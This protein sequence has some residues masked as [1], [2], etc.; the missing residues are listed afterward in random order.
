[1]IRAVLF[2]LDET[3]V[4]FR[5][6]HKTELLRLG[7]ERSYAYLSAHELSMPNF[8]QFRRKQ[9][10]IHR[11]IAWK[12][13]LTGAETDGRQ[14]LRRMCRDYGLQR[15]EPS[16]IKLGWLWFEP[17]A[18]RARVAADV[19]PTLEQLRDAGLHLGLVVNTNHLG[20]VNDMMLEN[21]GLLKFFTVRAYSTEVG[22]R[23]PAPHLFEY[24]L[25]QM[26]VSPTQALFV[27]DDLRADILGAHRTGLH[28]AWLS[29]G[30]GTGDGEADYEIR[31]IAD[32]IDVLELPRSASMRRSAI[33]PLQFEDAIRA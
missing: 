23:K 4:R 17:I 25:D 2:D 22:A 21:L 8:E 10:W 29:D 1:M 28:T 26:D 18:E 9:E 6:T 31:T 14:M 11:R 7:A 27:G 13:W 19:V 12:N 24:A 20:A 3:L 15:D 33:P 5:P 32:L 30:D 16:L